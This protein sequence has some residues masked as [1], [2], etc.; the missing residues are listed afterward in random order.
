MLSD[1]VAGLV[2]IIAGG[3]LFPGV[4]LQKCH[5]VS[6]GD[7]ADV[8]TVPLF[9]VDK[10]L[11][12]SNLAYL[13]L[14]QFAKREEDVR[15]LVLGQGIQEITLIFRGVCCLAQQEPAV[16][17]LSNPGVMAG[18]HMT[19]TQLQGLFQQVAE[20]QISVALNAGV[21][22]QAGFVLLNEGIHNLL[23]E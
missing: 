4:L 18:D 8:L 6:I 14:G 17:C 11:L 2:Q 23:T 16:F 13:R 5:V 7:E 21:G 12:L 22:G 15:Q 10:S 9:G 3:I 1:Y 20:F 19:A